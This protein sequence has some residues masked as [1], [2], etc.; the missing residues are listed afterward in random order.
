MTPLVIHP[1]KVRFEDLAS[2]EHAAQ[3][4]RSED[5]WADAATIAAEMRAAGF[6]PP[7][8]LPGS[9]VIER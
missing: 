9:R 1:P 5:S 8:L 6:K 4:E 2:V 3:V 7:E